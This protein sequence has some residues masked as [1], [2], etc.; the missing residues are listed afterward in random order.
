MKRGSR[1]DGR[2]GL[3]QE[4]G[5]QD[6]GDCNAEDRQEVEDVANDFKEHLAQKLR[7]AEVGRKAYSMSDRS[8]RDS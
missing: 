7:T 5:G 3:R 1:I 6:P 4:Y 8:M 2:L